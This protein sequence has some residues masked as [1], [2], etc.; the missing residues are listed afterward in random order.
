MEEEIPMRKTKEQIS[1]QEAKKNLRNSFYRASPARAIEK[2][3]L[4]SVLIALEVG[5]CLGFSATARR[6][7]LVATD[8]L[9]LSSGRLMARALHFIDRKR[10]KKETTEV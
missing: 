6:R 3:P 7:S 5:V 1:L 4:L 2:R 8:M 9:L 10:R